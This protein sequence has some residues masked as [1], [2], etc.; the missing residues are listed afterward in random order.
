MKTRLEAYILLERAMMDLDR[1]GDPLADRIRDLM[2]PLWY[3]LTDEEH[4]WL[5]QRD[6]REFVGPFAVAAAP[7][8]APIPPSGSPVSPHRT[9][10]IVVSLDA[11]TC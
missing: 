4:A 9:D 5:D 2:D 6:F 1:E 3:E 8:F 7:M 11:L 10:P